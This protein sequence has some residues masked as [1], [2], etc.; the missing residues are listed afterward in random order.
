[1]GTI[2]VTF[3]VSFASMGRPVPLLTAA[4]NLS[5]SSSDCPI[6]IPRSSDSILGHE[7]LH[8]ITDAPAFSHFAASSVHSSSLRPM[9]EAMI[10]LVGN[11]SL[12]CEKIRVFSSTLWSESCSIFL[13]PKNA[14]ECPLTDEKRGDASC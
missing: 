11:S 8:S 13:K 5:I 12:S 6:V 9:M 3:G 10:T 7:K 4:V 14:L 2:S 1:M